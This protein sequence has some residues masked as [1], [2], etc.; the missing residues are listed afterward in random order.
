M[1]APASRGRAL[2][3]HRPKASMLPWRASSCLAKKDDGTF[4]AI[5]DKAIR[6]RAIKESL[7]ASSEGVRKHVK[8]RKILKRK[9]ALGALDLSRLAKAAGLSCSDHHA[10]AVAAASTIAP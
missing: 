4:M 8:G 9:N 2:R 10:M 1:A 7:E 5:E 3:G 6:C